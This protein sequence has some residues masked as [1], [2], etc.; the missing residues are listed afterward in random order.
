MTVDGHLTGDVEPTSEVPDPVKPM[1]GKYDVRSSARLEWR[2]LGEEADAYETEVTVAHY[3]ISGVFHGHEISLVCEKGQMRKEKWPESANDP[4]LA[5][6]LQSFQRSTAGPIRGKISRGKRIKQP[7]P[8]GAPIVS[9][10]AWP[11]LPPEPAAVGQTWIEEAP[12]GALLLSSAP[13]TAVTNKFERL[14]TRDGVPVAVITTRGLSRMPE[15]SAQRERIALFALDAG[16]FVMVSD[17]LTFTVHSRF[18]EPQ[19]FS[20]RAHTEI[21]Q[22]LEVR[23]K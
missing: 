12:G 1:L 22:V 16:Y 14:D 11:Q 5:Q 10:D 15:G 6:L 7:A 9:P 4:L 18:S 20:A 17:A 13:E 3:K 23:K 21:K 19:P 2:I 8:S